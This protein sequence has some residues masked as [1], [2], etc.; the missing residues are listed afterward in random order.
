MSPKS[1]TGSDLSFCERKK[2]R[3]SK[4]VKGCNLPRLRG[5]VWKADTK[6]SDKDCRQAQAV[7]KKDG[8]RQKQVEQ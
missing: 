5:V 4:Y 1:C 2:E 8:N 3:P 7:M 6:E